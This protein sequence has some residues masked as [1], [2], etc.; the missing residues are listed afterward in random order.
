M[1]RKR[2]QRVI[3]EKGEA[4]AEAGAGAGFGL[5]RSIRLQPNCKGTE[6]S[7]ELFWGRECGT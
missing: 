2:R 1:E 3:D 5:G 7:S 6:I 4:G